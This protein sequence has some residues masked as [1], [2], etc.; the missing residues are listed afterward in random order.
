MTVKKPTDDTA[1]TFLTPA[2]APSRH[3]WSLRCW[4][5]RAH[6]IRGGAVRCVYPF[7]YG[8]FLSFRPKDGRA[9]RRN[10]ITFF[11]DP[12]LYD[13]IYK[14][15]LD[16]HC[17]ATLLNVVLSIPVAMRVRLM[18]RQ[19]LLTTILGHPDHARHDADR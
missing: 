19:K 5:C 2:P 3:R 9:V 11:S 13:T 1:S 4:F 17:P 7:L 10:H 14:T 6:W 18:R 15:L 16:R 12:Y 8:L